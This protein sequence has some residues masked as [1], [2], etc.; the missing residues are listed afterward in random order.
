MC[1]IVCIVPF[2]LCLMMLLVCLFVIYTHIYIHICVYDALFS[3][4]INLRFN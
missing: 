1:M 4:D 2:W 3:Y